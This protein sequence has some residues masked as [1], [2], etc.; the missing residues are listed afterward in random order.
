MAIFCGKGTREMVLLP[1]PNKRYH[2]REGYLSICPFIS[3]SF[4]WLSPVL[5]SS[6]WSLSEREAT[7]LET[8]GSSSNPRNHK[9]AIKPSSLRSSSDRK[10]LMYSDEKKEESSFHYK[11]EKIACLRQQESKSGYRGLLVGLLRFD[12]FIK[13]TSLVKKEAFP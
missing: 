8:L 12:F 3:F 6:F 11:Q 9:T 1:L 4:P 2:V 13:K 5:L 10:L 7:V